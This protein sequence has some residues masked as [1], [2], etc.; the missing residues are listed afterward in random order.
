MK[1]ILILLVGISLQS[2][3]TLIPSMGQL[4][5]ESLIE[6]AEIVIGAAEKE[7]QALKAKPAVQ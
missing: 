4:A 3:T 2:C 7:V 6:E 1:I 5:E